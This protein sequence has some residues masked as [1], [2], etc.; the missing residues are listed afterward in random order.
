[1]QILNK[2]SIK[3]VMSQIYEKKKKRIKVLQIKRGKKKSEKGRNKYKKIEK[4]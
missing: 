1:M 4:K 2:M 3:Q